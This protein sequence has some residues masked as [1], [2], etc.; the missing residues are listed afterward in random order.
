MSCDET[1]TI[2][3]DQEVELSVVVTVKRQYDYS[4]K[5]SLSQ[6]VTAPLYITRNVKVATIAE[7]LCQRA[8]Q[9]FMAALRK[10]QL[11]RMHEDESTTENEEMEDEVTP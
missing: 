8:I 7:T 2:D 11:Q 3:M 9:R 5:Q 1:T 4:T 6:T 10:E